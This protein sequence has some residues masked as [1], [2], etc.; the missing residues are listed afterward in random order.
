MLFESGDIRVR[1]Y[2]GRSRGAYRLHSCIL[3]RHVDGSSLYA[4]IVMDRGKENLAQYVNFNKSLSQ[5]T[6]RCLG[7]QL[8]NG[9][10]ACHQM[11]VGFDIACERLCYD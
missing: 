9:L 8:V 7:K 10:R 3:E 2:F 5:S 4:L 11:N 1:Q 6:I